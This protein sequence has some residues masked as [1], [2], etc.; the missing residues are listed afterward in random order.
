MN[1]Y[2]NNQCRVKYRINVKEI[3]QRI[4][5]NIPNEFICG[6][7]EIILL[8][9]GSEDSP[10]C[11]YIPAI[12]SKNNAKIEIYLDNKDFTQIPFFSVII[13]NVHFILAINEHIDQLSRKVKNNRKTFQINTHKINYDWMYLGMWN[14]LLIFFKILNK[15]IL[16]EY[17]KGLIRAWNNKLTKRNFRK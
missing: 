11:R 10:M 15:L 9:H 2:I 6:L 1:P 17:L 12:K 3:I 8:D 7:D 13:I 16:G 5:A 14:P 4:I